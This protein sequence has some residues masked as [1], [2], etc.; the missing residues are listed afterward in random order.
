MSAGQATTVLRLRDS[1][2][3]GIAQLQLSASGEVLA[4]SDIDAVT[5][6]TGTTVAFDQWARWQLCS[7]YS[8]GAPGEVSV[9]IGGVGVG[10]WNWSTAPI[11]QIQIGSLK[12]TTTV[13][14][15]DDLTVTAQ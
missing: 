5:E 12:K 7:A 14:N 15:L 6:S 13:Y 3:G 1:L 4:R 9:S 8:E 2:G 11:G 10:S